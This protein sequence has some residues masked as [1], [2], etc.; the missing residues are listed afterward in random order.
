MYVDSCLFWEGTVLLSNS[1]IPQIRE[2]LDFRARTA[3][4]CKC[5]E[6]TLLITQNCVSLLLYIMLIERNEILLLP[7]VFVVKC[8]MGPF[9]DA[10]ALKN[11]PPTPGLNSS[12]KKHTS[13][14]KIQLKMQKRG[15]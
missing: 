6:E 9:W 15:F 2:I 11:P 14:P 7:L 3:R 13:N 4:S 1:L 10:K 12:L 8:T 5:R